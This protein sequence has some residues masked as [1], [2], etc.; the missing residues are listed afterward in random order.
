[1][2]ITSVKIFEKVAGKSSEGVSISECLMNGGD[3][4]S[5]SLGTSFTS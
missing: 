2:S 4:Y 1:M 5:R 3:V